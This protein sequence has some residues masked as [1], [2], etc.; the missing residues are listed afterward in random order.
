MSDNFLKNNIIKISVLHYTTLATTICVFISVYY[1]EYIKQIASCVLCIYQRIPY[2][3]LLI[4]SIQ[5]LAKY[6]NGKISVS[7]KQTI[8]NVILL[9]IC[10]ILVL[11]S[12]IML[13][14][15]HLAVEQGIINHSCGSML[16]NHNLFQTKN[17]L[18]NILEE[19]QIIS[20][21]I[22]GLFIFGLSLTAWNFIIN[23]LLVIPYIYITYHLYNKKY[24]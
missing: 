1:I 21:N 13:A 8:D 14:G 6:Y 23:L 15:Y 16:I 2:I 22:P 4:F 5:I 17:I 19:R 9:H 18:E 10:V 12:A 7:K 24:K 11:I 3:A 20:C